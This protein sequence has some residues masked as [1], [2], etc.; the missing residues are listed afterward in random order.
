MSAVMD[1]S[2]DEDE[3]ADF[4]EGCSCRVWAIDGWEN[5]ALASASNNSIATLGTRLWL[6]RD[7]KNRSFDAKVAA[8]LTLQRS[9][10]AKHNK[11]CIVYG[12]FD[13]ADD[14]LP[15]HMWLEYEGY[16]YDTVPGDPLCRKKAGEVNRY[17]PGCEP[18]RQPKAMV[19][20][21]VTYLTKRQSRVIK[22]AEGNWNAYG[23]GISTYIP[24]DQVTKD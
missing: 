17:F 23:R 14:I 19:G 21:A 1:V 12:V 15:T 11:Q 22:A 5:E 4:I 7:A 18:R 3:D 10:P 6:D 13:S 24:A 8:F 2:D 16:I 9:P 20:R